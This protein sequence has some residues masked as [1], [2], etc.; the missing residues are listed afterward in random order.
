M[1]RTWPV[2]LAVILGALIVGSG[3]GYFL[4]LAN[5]DRKVLAEEV[6]RA[7]EQAE[8]VQ[9][10]SKATV[11]DANERVRIAN[12]EIHRAQTQ[13]S[14]LQEERRLI[15]DATP[16]LYPPSSLTAYFESVISEPLGFSV[17]Y[18]MGAVVQKNTTSSLQ[19]S[20]SEKDTDSESVWFSAIPYDPA[21]ELEW[22]ARISSTTVQTFL[23]DGRLLVGR[24]G[25]LE[26]ETFA[27]AYRVLLNGTNTHLIWIQDPPKPILKTRT[28][29]KPA[30]P[31]IQDILGTLDFKD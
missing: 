6:Q 27:G 10:N 4:Y 11:Q 13:L 23:V 9:Q 21:R 17:Q 30:T 5:E 1:S 24:T 12:E 20:M 26:D 15:V 29:R 18:P 22:I 16:L 25:L 14:V 28:W 8:E 19:L 3:T 2:L 31:E 7:R